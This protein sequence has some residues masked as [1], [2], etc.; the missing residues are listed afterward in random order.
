MR[1]YTG[2][3][4]GDFYYQIIKDI[5]E[6]GRKVNIRG[7]D[8]LEFPDRVCLEYTAPGHCWMR[9]PGRKFNPFF[10]LAEVVW[11]L[12]GSGNVEWI[13]YFN[14]K[15]RDFSDGK[16]DF[17]G[18]YGK[19]LRHWRI[20][21]NPPYAKQLDQIDMVVT[22]LTSDEH[23]RQAV[24]SIWDP[25]LDNL[26]LSKDIPC[27]SLVYY[28]LRN[29]VLNQTVVIRSND[30]VWGTPYNAV[31]FS[32]IHAYVAGLLNVEIGTLTYIVQNLHYY[33]DL[34]KPTLS[35]LIERAYY[36]Y[37]QRSDKLQAESTEEFSPFGDWELLCLKKDVEISIEEHTRRTGVDIPQRPIWSHDYTNIMANV[38]RLFIKVKSGFN[39]T[40]SMMEFL[41]SLKQPFR[42]LIEDFY[43][44]SKNPTAQHV[45]DFLRRN[46]D[47]AA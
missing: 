30:A 25:E 12:S 5:T 9:I 47:V 39:L 42:G 43:E 13:S 46:N 7:N 10:A 41:S 45:V 15:M 29:N 35:N 20:H 14:E 32:H 4:L 17:H 22:K 1:V 3:G 36:H 27:N 23:T 26:T 11:I 16:E 28:E 21:D 37:D 44:S 8:C 38:I 34:Y 24:M 18:S 40:T 19:R 2:R 33:L 31:Q 6:H